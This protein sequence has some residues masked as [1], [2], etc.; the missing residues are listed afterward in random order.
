MDGHA[1]QTQDP[2]EGAIRKAVAA[3][4]IGNAVE[5]FDFALYGY[6]SVI[7]GA[8]LTPSHDPAVQSLT[9]WGI[10]AVSF[11]IRPVGSI[12]LGPLGDKIGRKAVLAVTILAMTVATLAVG[13]IPSYES[14]GIAAPILLVLCRLVQGFSTGGE[15]AGA[16]TF[17]AE[18]APNRR[19]GF[20][21]SFLEF[22]T[23]VGYTLGSGLVLILSSTLT[24]ANMTSW[25]WRIPFL[26]TA[27]LGLVGVYLRRK[28]NDSPEFE[29]AQ[30]RGEMRIPFLQLLAQAWRRLLM[31][32]GIVILLN[33]GYYIMLTYL[34]E[35]LTKQLGLSET[36]AALTLIGIYVMMMI[37]IAPIGKLSDKFGRRPMLQIACGGFFLLSVP[38]FL[39]VNTGTVW[40]IGIGLV[41]MA[42]LLLPMAST[43]PATLPALFPTRIR[44]GA[45]AIGY[46]VSTALFGGTAPV[47]VTFLITATG[48]KLIPGFYLMA[49]A[50]VA[51][52]AIMMMPETSKIS[53]ADAGTSREKAAQQ[54]PLQTA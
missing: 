29:N 51:A 3:A 33:V 36:Q 13:L 48:S 7:I 53:M 8:V 1:V 31:L 38:S 23:Y 54:A 11:L 27:P 28:L 19:R 15:Y 47:I 52:P 42:L 30:E 44:Y 26:V 6:L 43:I 25:G 46:N 32:V 34:P 16:A 22:G 40:G 5:W 14:I 20:L 12:V 37:L 18:Y 50:V 41:V 35:Y 4:A 9:T 24:E 21:G 17:I 39:L 45:F 10:F 2:P 49:A